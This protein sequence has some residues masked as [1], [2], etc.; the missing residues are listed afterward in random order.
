MAFGVGNVPLVGV[1][2]VGLEGKAEA[3]RIFLATVCMVEVTGMP[4]VEAVRRRTPILHLSFSDSREVDLEALLC[5]PVLKAGGA[6]WGLVCFFF[7]PEQRSLCKFPVK[8]R[9]WGAPL[10]AASTSAFLSLLS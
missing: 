8:R 4:R 5:L 6:V 3:G 10:V 9:K 1:G 7:K 2:L